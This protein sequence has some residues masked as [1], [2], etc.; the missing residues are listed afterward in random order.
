MRPDLVALT[1]DFQHYTEDIKGAARLLAPAGEWSRGERDGLG[2]LAVLGNHDTWSGTPEVTNALREVGITVLNNRHV[3][4]KRAGASLYVVGVADPWSLRADLPRAL[5]GVPQGACKL[6]LAHVPDFVVDAAGAGVD[7][8]LS[9]HTHGGQL[10]HGGQITLPWVG[11]LLSPSRYNRR[12]VVG[13]HK[14]GRTL[15]YVCRGLG[16]HP[17][18]RL[19]CKPEIALITL[20][21]VNK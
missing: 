8:Q 12:Y 20:R 1:G 18:I 21:S 11:A 2:A 6:L 10:W 4:I 15:M 19:G 3:E 17:S 13:W 16:G 5:L 14:R 9:G 7:L